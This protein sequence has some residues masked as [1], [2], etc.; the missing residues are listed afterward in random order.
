MRRC[1]ILGH[2]Y[3]TCWRKCGPQPVEPEGRYTNL[4]SP[5]IWNQNFHWNLVLS[6]SYILF[7]C[8]MRLD[9]WKK[10]RYVNGPLRT[11]KEGHLKWTS[12]ASGQVDKLLAQVGRKDAAVKKVWNALMILM[13]QIMGFAGKKVRILGL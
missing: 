4:T 6:E 5:L 7:N 3:R 8:Q 9:P 13:I 1:A 10:V 11:V 12:W 2:S